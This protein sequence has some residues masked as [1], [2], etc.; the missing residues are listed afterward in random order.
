MNLQ[1]IYNEKYQETSDINEHLPVL[2]Q[3]AEKC[4]HITE[5]GVRWV[6]STYAFMMGRPKKLRSYDI[7][8]IE[9]H[10]VSREDLISLAKEN[11]VDFE[12]IEGDTLQINIEETDLLFIDTWHTYD[13]LKKEL[14]LHNNKV[15]KYIILHDTTTFGKVGE[16]HPVGLWPAVEEFLNINNNWVIEEKLENN[17]GLTIL[18][19]NK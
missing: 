11:D 18:K 15:R 3:Y 17:N 19:N 7:T 2:K 5:F 9:N 10:N 12:F 16:G 14:E 6:V 8:P 13:Q 4:N 1:E